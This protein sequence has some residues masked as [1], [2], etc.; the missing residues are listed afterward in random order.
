MADNQKFTVTFSDRETGRTVDYTITGA[1]LINGKVRPE[2]AAELQ[3]RAEAYFDSPEPVETRAS[4]VA[5]Q[6]GQGLSLGFADEIEAGVRAPFSDRSYDQIANEIRARNKAYETANPGK[7]FGMQLGGGLLTGGAGAARVATLKGIQQAPKLLRYG[8]TYPGVGAAEGAIAGAGYADPGRRGTGAL[9]GS[10]VGA[11]AGIAAPLLVGGATKA[12]SPIVTKISDKAAEKVAQRAV[13]RSLARDKMTPEQGLQAMKDMGEGAA[14]FDVGPNVSALGGTIANRPGAGLTDV[15]DFVEARRAGQPTRV[16]NALKNA[17]GPT[18]TSVKLTEE[19]GA[20]QSALNKMVPF[21]DE[22]QELISRPAMQDAWKEAQITARNRGIPLED[23][24]DVF[25]NANRGEIKTELLHL[26]K[27]GLDD[28]IEPKRGPSGQLSTEYGQNRLKSMQDLRTKFRKLAGDLNEDYD[29]VLKASFED[30]KLGSAYDFGERDALMPSVSIDDVTARVANMSDAE[31]RALRTGTI[32]KIEQMVGGRAEVG[33]DITAQIIRQK[34]K[35]DVIFGDRSEQLIRTIKN[36]RRIAQNEGRIL[37]G[38]DTARRLAAKEDFEDNVAQEIAGVMGDAATGN[39][40]GAVRG[41]G[42]SVRDFA[43][44]PPEAVGAKA[45]QM[46]FQNNPELVR[47]M[48]Q[49]APRTQGGMGAFAF[50]SAVPQIVSPFAP[51]R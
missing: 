21:T 49:G 7:A 27:K 23:F 9:V 5:R 30:K 10:G 51:Q 2:L 20:F 29:K 41:V 4:D 14:L 24:K 32:K 44:R 42:K 28:V 11:G 36:E 12:V 35:L 38:S 25:Q 37:S 40:P 3:A 33:Q 46:L 43:T 47:R 1:D 39:I 13:A 8:A 22:L 50:G 16:F 18:G 34:N 6:V 19:S 45:A 31:L 15:V 26:L 17:V 48:L